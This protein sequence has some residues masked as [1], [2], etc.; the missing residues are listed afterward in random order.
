MQVTCVYKHF[1]EQLDRLTADDVRW[2]PY[3]AQEMEHRAPTGLSSLCWCDQ[4]Y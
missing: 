2:E 4:A 3:S 1:V